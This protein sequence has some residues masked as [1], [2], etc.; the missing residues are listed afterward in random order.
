MSPPTQVLP[1]DQRGITI[2]YEEL[3]L[4]IAMYICSYLLSNLTGQ[5]TTAACC[6]SSSKC[7]KTPPVRNLIITTLTT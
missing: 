3:V 4:S 1:H 5:L 7:K 2:S 6:V